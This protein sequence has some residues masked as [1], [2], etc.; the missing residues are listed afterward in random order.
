MP[1]PYGW[2]RGEG[3]NKNQRWGLAGLGDDSSS[4][5]EIPG[6]MPGGGIFPAY[7][8]GLTNTPGNTSVLL[9]VG[10]DVGNTIGNPITSF[11]DASGQ[12][13][14]TNLVVWGAIAIGVAVL[15]T[16]L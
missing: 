16:K 6:L 11:I 13:S 7:A 3:T 4:I 12:P 14:A 15:I 5:M 8:T 9:N 1:R 2:I 10:P